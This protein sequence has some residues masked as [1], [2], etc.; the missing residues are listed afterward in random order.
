VVF[1]PRGG[2]LHLICQAWNPG[3]DFVLERAGPRPGGNPP[4][5]LVA[6]GGARQCVPQPPPGASDSS[7]GICHS[8]PR[9][10]PLGNSGE[11]KATATTSCAPARAW[12]ML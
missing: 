7:L 6:C 12:R 4:P 9:R 11:A 10:P 5:L 3:H 2:S 8:P 1:H